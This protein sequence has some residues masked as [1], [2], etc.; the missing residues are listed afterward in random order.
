MT[1]RLRSVLGRAEDLDERAL[2]EVGLPVRHFALLELLAGGPVARQH[3]LGAAIGLDRTTT[4]SL[5]R[6]LDD[7][8]L[9]RRTPMPGNNRV[10][11]LE[12]TPDGSALL[13]DAARRLAECEQRLLAPLAPDERVL[14]RRAL[15]RLLE[16]AP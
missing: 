3:E 14:L 13:A 8:G 7:R 1:T 12:L 6:R 10:L 9:V 11:V 5:V 16:V 15:D 2:A 4:A